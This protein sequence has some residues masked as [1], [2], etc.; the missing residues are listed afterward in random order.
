VSKLSSL[1][2]H[3]ITHFT[4]GSIARLAALELTYDGNL[5]HSKWVSL[6]D[7][8]L[9]T[10]SFATIGVTENLPC[11]TGSIAAGTAGA[12][13]SGSLTASAN[14]VITADT[15]VMSTAKTFAVCYTDAVGDNTATWVDSGLRLTLSKVTTLEY[16]QFSTSFPV[17][18][19][20]SNNV[21]PATNVM[22][23]IP[24]AGVKFVGD[25]SNYKWLNLVK[26]SLNSNNPCVDG[27]TAAGKMSS[28]H[29]GATISGGGSG[30]EVY[31]AQSWVDSHGTRHGTYLTHGEIYAVCYCET[32]GQTFDTTWRDSYIRVASSKLGSL[33][34]HSITHFTD[35]SIARLATLKLTY[36]GDLAID[37]W[38][39]L[40]D[41]TLGSTANFPCET[42][43]VAAG[44]AGAQYSGSRSAASGTKVITVDT[45]VMST[46]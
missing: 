27:T 16:Q 9:G 30:K 24:L 38:V 45:T 41:A 19:W 15:T 28:T 18:S 20:P 37:K 6:V 7:A 42:A 12:Q 17:R 33:T 13:Y 22:P 14:K 32:N 39:S 5:V 40:V 3:S 21:R 4:D 10:T 2:S 44:T 34:S 29:T 36:G 26:V 23:H 25:L 1:S 11:A 8:S 31:F 46:A 35:G 43:S